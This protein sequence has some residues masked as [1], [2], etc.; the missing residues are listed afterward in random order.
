MSLPALGWI[1]G[2]N[3]VIEQR[4]AGG[5]ASL[6][7]DLAEQL[8]RLKVETIVVE[9]TVVALAAK[10]ATNTIPIVVARSGDPVRAG[11]VTSL[12][13]PGG[14]ITGTSTVS[15]DLD[16]KRFQILHELL[17]TAQRVGE[18]VVPANP[19]DLVTRADRERLLS[20]LGMLPVF[21]EVAQ[22]SDLE[23]AVAEAAR[24]GAQVLHVSAEPLLGQNFAQI[25]RAA[26]KYSLP[27]LVDNSGF[28]E[29]GGL[30]SYGPDNDELNRQL[31][32]FLDKILR[33]AK[34]ADLPIQQPR[35]F[36]LGI[37]LKSAK[38]FGI[39]V[40]QSLLLRADTVIQ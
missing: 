1:E 11:L 28:L 30:V 32:F 24:R 6:L 39:T 17:P 37:N 23:K 13:R 2:Q 25:L 26:Q 10:K 14:N 20:P 9:G 19:I 3:L 31:A 18:L 38:A 8:V 16:Y 21:V 40:P 29:S 22:S 4:Y 34:P 12:A 5:N 33:G 35:K 7:P 27:I 15:P 36:E